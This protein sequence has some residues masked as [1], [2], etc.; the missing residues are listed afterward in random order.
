MI[1]LPSLYQKYF[2]KNF[3]EHSLI[4]N[5]II[6]VMIPPNDYKKNKH[7]NDLFSRMLN[8]FSINVLDYY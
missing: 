6:I 8:N 1:T 3:F 2:C 4:C 7:S 5:K